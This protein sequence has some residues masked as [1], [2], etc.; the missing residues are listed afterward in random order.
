MRSPR[1]PGVRAPRLAAL[2]AC[3]AQCLSLAVLCL[4]LAACSSGASNGSSGQARS[5]KAARSSA[6][7]SPAQPAT[8]PA[9]AAAVKAMWQTFFNGAVP[10]PRRLDL[11][12]DGQ[13]FA[14]FV[15]S[16]AKTSLGAL[17]LAA[18]GKVSAVRLQPPDHASVTYSILLGG[19][20]VAKNLS[21]TAVYITGRWQ[22]AV[23]TFCALVHVA[24]GKKSNLI[25][26]PCR[27]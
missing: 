9:A 10:I 27:S 26:A 8:G 12:Q 14:S 7:A 19:K 17:V 13:Q 22:V 6:P 11:L 23:T 16:Q 25:P 21:G 5:G 2:S 3:A 18:S 1:R 15:H 4:A 24:Y 20:T